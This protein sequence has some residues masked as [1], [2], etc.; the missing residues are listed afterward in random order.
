[1]AAIVVIVRLVNARTTPGA[2]AETSIA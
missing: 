2:E 1:V